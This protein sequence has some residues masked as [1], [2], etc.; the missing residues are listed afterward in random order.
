MQNYEQV[1]GHLIDMLEELDG[2]LSK[3]TAEV[4]HDDEPLS[5]D[6]A[7]QVVEMENNEVLD[8][9]GNSTRTEIEKIKQAII[10]MDKG[11]Y[12]VCQV[13][14][15]SIAAERLLA[16]PFSSMCIKCATQ[17]EGC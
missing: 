6:F 7:E 16:I 3:I 10:N 2:R 8:A 1:R 4:R 5:H 15:E 13:C 12:G 9:L 17:A 11:E 14:G